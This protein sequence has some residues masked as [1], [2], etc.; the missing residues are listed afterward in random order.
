MQN[1][2]SLPCMLE[3]VVWKGQINLILI[4]HYLLSCWLEWTCR[5]T[6]RASLSDTC[7]VAS[8]LVSFANKELLASRVHTVTLYR[9]QLPTHK[10]LFIDWNAGITS[11]PFSQEI[12]FSA[13]VDKNCV[14]VP[15]S[16]N[17]IVLFYRPFFFSGLLLHV[18]NARHPTV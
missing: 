3:C 7:G 14:R 1:D 8:C 11:A 2:I 13:I 4:C 16:C 10:H 12:H 18:N 5:Q 15:S 9:Q 6:S 17:G